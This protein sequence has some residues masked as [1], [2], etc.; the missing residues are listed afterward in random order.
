MVKR[1]LVV[2]DVHGRTF[3]KKPVH[4]YLNQVNKVV[5]L[6]DYLDPYQDEGIEYTPEGVYENL[7][8]IILLKQDNKEKVVLLKG[9]HDQHY[10]SERFNELAGGTRQDSLNWDKYHKV[11]NDFKD[12]FQLAHLEQVND[13]PY[14]FTHAGLTAF[15]LNKVNTELWHLVDSEVSV[16]DPE[17]VERINLLDDDG[18]G[19]DLLSVVGS[20]R[21]WFG[22][23]TGGV[24]WA[25]IRE[26][27]IPDAPKA[28][29]LDKVFQVFGHT[30]LDGR[31]EDMIAF[32]NLAMIDSQQCFMVGEDINEKIMPLLK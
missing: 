4:Q 7:M 31:Y 16:S 22:E 32:G 10:A 11:F 14:V 12:L 24:L 23:K 8:E 20:L 26:H 5:F 21:S 29:G 2:P 3:W 25:D 6:G 18:Q 19:Q 30:R 13:T 17:I 9:N 15:W 27:S 28:Y 1:I